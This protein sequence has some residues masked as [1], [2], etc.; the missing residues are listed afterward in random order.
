VLS[1]SGFPHNQ[2]LVL[3][4]TWPRA[5]MSG[6]S[7]SSKAMRPERRELIMRALSPFV[8]RICLTLIAAPLYPEVTTNMSLPVLVTAFVPCAAGGAGET[9]DLTGNLHV[10]MTMTQNANHLEVSLQ[11]QPQGISG[12]GSVTGDRYQGTG[13]TRSRFTMDVAG[14]PVSTTF[15]NNFRVVGQTSGNDFLVHENFHLTVNGNGA[16]TAFLD[17]FSVECK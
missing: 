17:N 3:V 10:L 16:A 15:V 4:K 1:N 11:F 8:L 7:T 5:E 13:V 2:G 9:V 6:Q 14:F 12:T